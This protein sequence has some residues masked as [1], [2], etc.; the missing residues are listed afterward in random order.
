LGHAVAGMSY[1]VYS[2]DG[3]GLKRVAG[4]VEQITYEG[5]RL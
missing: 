2:Q 3:P 5:L 4:V 1:R